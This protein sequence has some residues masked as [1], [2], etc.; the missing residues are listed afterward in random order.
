[1]FQQRCGKLLH[2]W[3]AQRQAQRYSRGLVL[4]F[5]ELKP[6]V[7]NNWG[8]GHQLLA[9]YQLHELCLRTRRYCYISLYDVG[10]ERY[11]GYAAG[12]G[13]R[14]NIGVKAAETWD[15]EAADELS[16]YPS[17]QSFAI[18]CSIYERRGFIERVML[19]LV[20]SHDTSALLE[21][22]VSG[23]LPGRPNAASL[24]AWSSRRGRPVDVNR[25]YTELMTERLLARS[26]G[27]LD[28][29]SKSHLG[30]ES[31]GLRERRAADPLASAVFFS[32]LWD[33]GCCLC[34]YNRPPHL[35]TPSHPHPPSLWAP[36]C[37]LCRYLLTY[38]LTLT[39]G[40][41]VLPVQVRN[42][43]ARALGARRRHC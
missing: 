9:L 3:R 10:L 4:R 40:S 23:Y 16:R 42:G 24:P 2:S 22:N 36:G 38:S 25:D 13:I 6:F 5:R 34:R 19:P 37:C 11:F 8:I 43:A 30:H 32:S 7:V 17:R 18:N 35:W 12:D 28:D 20:R 14:D 26:R 29:D 41:W 39:L 31:K 21:I 33:P 1:M 15:P 27:E